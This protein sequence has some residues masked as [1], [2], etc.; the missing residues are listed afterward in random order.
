MDTENKGF[1]L[2]KRYKPMID[3]LSD[4]QAG[5]LIRILFAYFETWEEPQIEDGMI[6]M[7]FAMV[8]ADMKAADENWKKMCSRNAENG[9]KGGRP[10]KAE[11]PTETEG[12]LQK[13]TETEENP[14]KPTGFFGNPQEPKKAKVKVKV[15][16]K[17]NNISN[18]LLYTAAEPVAEAPAQAEADCESIPLNDGTEWKPTQEQFEEYERLYPGVDVKQAF[19]AMRGWCL[20]NPTRRK[21]RRGVTA[22]VTSW[23]NREQNRAPARADPPKKTRFDN[24]ES[25]GTDYDA[26][27]WG[28]VTGGKA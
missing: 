9:R 24:F 4:E 1:M 27:M 17:V 25:H 14:Q 21:T 20:S 16:E 7:V 18:N 2:Y 12:N 28:M 6:K 22:F 10:R 8:S 5:K 23:M 11:E 19:R 13:P 26:L 15:K 3:V